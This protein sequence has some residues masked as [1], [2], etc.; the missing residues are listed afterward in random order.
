MIKKNIHLQ[1]YAVLKDAR[2][3]SQET[4]QTHALTALELYQ[5][6]QKKYHFKLT[7]NLLKVA[8]NNQFADWSTPIHDG[9]SLV[10]IPPVAGG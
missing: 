7:T 8:I 9:D 6:L 2:G 5:D 4:I 10:F 3:L 1:Y